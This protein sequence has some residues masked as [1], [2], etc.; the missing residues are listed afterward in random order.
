M[1]TLVYEAVKIGYRHIDTAA[2]YRNEDGIGR[3]ITRILKEGNIKRSELYITTKI[4]PKDQGFENT[5][6]A[7]QNSLKNLQLEYIDL[8]LIHWPGTAKLKP[9]DIQ[10]NI[11]RKETIKALY[12]SFKNG[13]LKSIG[14]SNFDVKHFDGIT[15][16]IHANQIEFHPLLY[17]EKTINLLKYCHE[18]QICAIAY[19]CFGHGKLF[20]D[21][22]PEFKQIA[23]E[24]GKTVAQV[25]IAWVLT[26]G[27]IVIPKTKSIERLL[28]NL[29][30]I[31]VVLSDKHILIIDGV[32][33]RVGPLKFCWDPSA[34]V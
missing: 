15:V 3:A 12:E 32:V 20:D 24:L 19:S 1:E 10:N 25:L 18:N 17:T 9:D 33:G 31:N 30:A 21:N 4:A 5:L 2:V 6:K 8:M 28:E 7:I 14:V 34:V 22:Y 23:Q 29:D 11:N 13:Q 26:K 16:P 27:L